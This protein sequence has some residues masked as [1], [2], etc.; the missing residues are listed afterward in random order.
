[1]VAA[2]GLEGPSYR[3]GYGRAVLVFFHV[4]TEGCDVA[5]VPNM[6]NADVW[7]CFG[8][9]WIHKQMLAKEGRGVVCEREHGPPLVMK[10]KLNEH[11]RVRLLIKDEE[12]YFLRMLRRERQ[13]QRSEL[14]SGSFFFFFQER[15]EDWKD[16]KEINLSCLERT[17]HI[18][19][20]ERW[21]AAC[22]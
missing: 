14:D 18:F 1:M 21:E 13:A 9:E 20:H 11:K 15:V 2:A 10:R 3:S 16:K 17:K 8:M 4:S 12:H 6:F 7:I 5:L 22:G 19:Q